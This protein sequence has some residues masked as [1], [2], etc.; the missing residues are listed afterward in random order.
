MTEK[1]VPIFI[2]DGNEFYVPVD[3][4]AGKNETE[5]Y[6]IGI[7]VTFVEGIIYGFKFTEKILKIDLRNTLMVEARIGSLPVCIVGGPIFESAETG[8]ICWN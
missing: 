2:K 6:H 5:A 4:F 8:P 7:G 1:F 3:D